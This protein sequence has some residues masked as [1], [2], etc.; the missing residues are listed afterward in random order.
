[1]DIRAITP[2][3]PAAPAEPTP[4]SPASN[5]TEVQAVERNLHDTSG[6]TTAA[7]PG[8]RVTHTHAEMRFDETL[9]RVVGRI[10]NEQTGETILEIP[11][12]QLK[13]LYTKMREQL[14]PLVDETA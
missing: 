6:G 4:D 12:E 5:G 8:P 3:I 1:M 11:P 7:A 10:V 2:T 9:N 14:G 13:A